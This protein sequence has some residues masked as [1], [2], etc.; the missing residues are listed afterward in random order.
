MTKY[1]LKYGIADELKFNAGG[2]AVED[3]NAILENQGY[4]PFTINVKLI[5][6]KLI[7]SLRIFKLLKL[8]KLNSKDII[9]IPHPLGLMHR[10]IDVI[11]LI[12]AIKKFKICY[13]IHDL[14]SIRYP[15]DISCQYVDSKM[16]KDADAVIVHNKIMQQYV[17]NKRQDLKIAC[18]N[19]FDYLGAVNTKTKRKACTLNVAGNL[20]E[21]KAQY[22]YHAEK[23][24][25]NI[26]INLYGANYNDKKVKSSNFRYFGKFPPEDIPK[27]FSEGFGLVWDG[28]SIETCSGNMGNY[29]RYNNP[30]KLSLYLS[31]G[32]PVVVWE[33][34]ATKEFVLENNV[35]IAVNNIN[36]FYE[37]YQKITD[38]D[39]QLMCHNAE[40]IAEKLH[41]GHF[42]RRA[43]CNINRNNLNCLP[44]NNTKMNI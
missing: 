5:K 22:L 37:K 6:N 13:L 35:G 38:Q 12:H 21:E 11:C 40:K 34:S 27:V 19:V 18:L 33:Q 36:E 15:S 2:K 42:L 10:Y 8:F 17:K 39:Y 44:E 29:L 4:L 31:A 24:N 16:I 25:E 14:S 1:Y 9:V 3:C 32:L 26:S 30:H 41:S 20:S 43:I 28:P 7:K 23:I